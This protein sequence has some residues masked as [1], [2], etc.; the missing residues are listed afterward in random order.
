MTA[1]CIL[2]ARMGSK[3]LPG[4]VLADLCGRPMLAHIIERLKEA[5]TISEVIVATTVRPEDEAVV[6]L[7]TE[8]GVASFRGPVDDVLGRIARVV[9][10]WGAGVIAHASG[11][12]P[13]TDPQVLDRLVSHHAE[14]GYDFTYMAGLPVG[15]GVDV[16]SGGTIMALDR[17]AAEPAYREHVNAYIFDH[18]GSF[19]AARLLPDAELRKPNIRLTVDTADDLKLV[20]EIYRRLYRAGRIVSLMD[21]LRLQE[22]EPEL[23]LVNAHVEQH[24]VSDA[25]R[26]M[27]GL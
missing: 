10:R 27:R 3:R 11:D 15:T 8:M 1:V 13:L 4:K 18:I 9:E 22:D 12:N 26:Q 21:V 7:A 23:F 25:A 17:L 16:F 20:R 24:Y 5:G 19:K 6:N 2:Q 14:G